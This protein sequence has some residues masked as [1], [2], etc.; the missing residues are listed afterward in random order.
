MAGF[1]QN[2]LRIQFKNGL[3]TVEAFNIQKKQDPNLIK[4]EKD[5]SEA[6]G[7][8]TKITQST[9]GSGRIVINFSSLGALQGILEK[10][11]D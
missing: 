3:L 4:L 11:K 8:K 7:A 1:N 5:I 9:K 10:I 2:S 6:L